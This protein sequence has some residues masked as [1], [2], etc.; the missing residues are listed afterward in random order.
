MAQF[1]IFG[2]RQLN[3]QL[4]D[5][6]KQIDNKDMIT[7]AAKEAQEGIEGNFDR[8]SDRKGGTWQELS[9]KRIKERKLKGTWPGKI[10]V[11]TG[12]LSEIKYN[13]L[14]ANEAK[15]GTEASYGNKHNVG[16]RTP[17]REW[18]YLSKETKEKIRK[19]V[20]EGIKWE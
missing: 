15:V 2:V 10:L 13:I 17:K 12:F 16:R 6:L 5:I 7:R 20:L 4:A 3:D 19:A 14:S 1:V 9:E 11:D 18:L 8:Q